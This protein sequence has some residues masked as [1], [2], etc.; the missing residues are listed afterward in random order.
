MAR[1]LL[2]RERAALLLAVGLHATAFAVAPSLRPESG[3][4]LSAPLRDATQL[5]IAVD[6]FA[7]PAP[8][9]PP[10]AARPG[11]RE[12][13]PAYKGPHASSQ[14]RPPTVTADIPRGSSVEVGPPG[15]TWTFSPTQAPDLARLSLGVDRYRAERPAPESAAPIATHSA[16]QAFA[17]ATPHDVELGLSRGSPIV[18]AAREAAGQ[19]DMLGTALFDITLDGS[20]VR[21]DLAH[22]NRDAADWDRL[23]DSLAKLVATRAIT[24]PSRGRGL[25]VRIQVDAAVKLADGRDVRVLGSHAGATL[26]QVGGADGIT[27]KEMPSLY[28]EHV[29]KNCSAR[30]ALGPSGG[31]LAAQTN[32]GV[33]RPKTAPIDLPSLLTPITVGGGCGV[34]NIGSPPRRMVAARVVSETQL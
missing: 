32:F 12:I 34:D 30:L 5:E 20:G 14:L 6:V 7:A 2:T 13:V 31:D 21:V 26:G 33:D 24:L 4:F 1:G 11:A 15:S 27:M 3:G 10:R 22:A 23:R 18:S 16:D 28:A 19:A 29:G 9:E 25:R 8:S 17:D